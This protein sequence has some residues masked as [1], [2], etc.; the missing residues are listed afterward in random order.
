MW[1]IFRARW[2]TLLLAALVIFVPLGLL[3]TLDASLQEAANEAGDLGTLDL[4]E[5]LAVAALDGAGALFGEVLFAGVVTAAVTGAGRG[6]GMVPLRELLRGLPIGRLALADLAFTIVVVLGFIALI[7]PGVLFLVWF[8]LLGPVIEVEKLGV[9]DAFRRSR[10]LVRIR[11]WLV[12]AFAIPLVVIDEAL[13]NLVH[14]ASIWSLG[15]TFAGEW[16]AG[17]LAEM[18]TAPLLALAVVVLYFE[19]SDVNEG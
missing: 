8:A 11:P 19:L 6:A 17:T 14:E 10:Q 3:E 13:V 15:E 7:V 16:A 1:A 2:L 9:R 4:I 12:A 5:V 18:L